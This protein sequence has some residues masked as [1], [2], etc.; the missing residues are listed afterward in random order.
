[1]R[2][3]AR[4]YYSLLGLLALSLALVGTSAEGQVGLTI[5]P[6]MTKGPA[7]APVTVVEF[8]DYQ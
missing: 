2:R 4:V 3:R 7:K 5:T 1:M 6:A 8:S